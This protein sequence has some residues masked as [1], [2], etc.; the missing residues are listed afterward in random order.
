VQFRVTGEDPAVLRSIADRMADIVRAH[1]D[2]RDVYNDWN[3]IVQ[4]L[5]V[6]V[7]QDKARSLGVSSQDIGNT[8]SGMMNGL[9][10]TQFR[11]GDKWIDVVTRARASAD[12]SLGAIGNLAVR[13]GTGRYVPLD[14]FVT[15][16]YGFEEAVLGR[17]NAMGAI[18]VGADVADDAQGPEVGRQLE[19]AMMALNKTLPTGY[20]IETGGTLDAVTRSQASLVVVVPMMVQVIVSLLML[21]MRSFKSAARVLICA[22]LGLGGVVTALLLFR[23]PFGFVAILGVTALAAIIMR[24][25]VILVE[26]IERFMQ[27]HNDPRRAIIEAAV[28]RLRPI[29]LTAAA[30]I[31]AM[32]PLTQAVFWRPMAVAMMGGVAVA[33]VL[34]LVFEPAIYAA[35]FGV[36]RSPGSSTRQRRKRRPDP[37]EFAKTQFLQE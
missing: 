17:R 9:P 2:T 13:T 5:R 16:S 3:E 27:T 28:R 36:P 34:T 33:T 29:M 22:P 11:E 31:L 12:R 35:W 21:Q 30:T 26:L 7:D 15:L 8:L 6:N 19:P 1:R 23:Q 14:H 37:V 24:N 18:T 20:R 4:T 10:V 32:V 25:S